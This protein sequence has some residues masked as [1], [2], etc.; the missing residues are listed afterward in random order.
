MGQLAEH[1]VN[2]PFLVLGLVATLAAV[3][4]FEVRQRAQG[5]A[6]VS[7]ADAV[8][9]INKGAVVIDVRKPADFQAGHIVNA[10]NVELGE[11]GPEQSVLKKQKNK[12]LIAVCDN[13]MSSSRA[14]GTLRKAGYE[15]VFNLK[16]GLSGWRAENLPLVK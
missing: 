13:G 8:R 14:A 11:V 15:K 6:S 7:A 10:K 1:V 4:F 16:G 9:L 3:L 5:S 2:H 12:V